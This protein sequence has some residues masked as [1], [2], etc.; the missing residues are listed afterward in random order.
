MIQL[1]KTHI[2]ALYIKKWKND[3]NKKLK[4]TL[5]SFMLKVHLPT[6]LTGFKGSTMTNLSGMI[7]PLDSMGLV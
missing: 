7:I 1:K 2:F 5:I 4:N 3:T 6:L